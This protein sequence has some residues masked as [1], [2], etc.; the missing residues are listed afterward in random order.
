MPSESSR[1]VARGGVRRGQS[2]DGNKS[3]AK[4]GKIRKMGRKRENWEENGKLAGSLPQRAGRVGYG[5]GVQ[6]V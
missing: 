3:A 2:A 1:A 5:P 6:C 4:T